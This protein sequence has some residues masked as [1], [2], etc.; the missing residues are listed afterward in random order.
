MNVKYTLFILIIGTL[1]GCT[2]DLKT[3]NEKPVVYFQAA[4]EARDATGQLFDSTVVTFA[5][6]SAS[7]KDSVVTVGIKVTGAPAAEDRPFALKVL[8]SSTAVAGKHYDIVSPMVIPAGKVTTQLQIKFHRQ[9]EMLTTPFQVYLALTANEHF[10][11]D[12][13]VK[14]LSGGKFVFTT[15]HRVKADD[16]L[17]RPMY[18]LDTYLGTFSRK[19]LYLM[20]EILEIPI[21][22]LNTSVTVAEVNFYGKFMQRYLNEQKANGNTIKEDDGADMLM[23]PSVQ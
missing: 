12:L 14:N 22:K 20:S 9:P 8:D 15:W 7:L 11:T 13:L 23:G 4:V 10:G 17:A 6:A 3:F 18:W 1:A 21:N 16:I 2:K 19:K 5:Y